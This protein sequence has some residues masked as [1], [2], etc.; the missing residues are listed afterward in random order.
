MNPDELDRHIMNGSRAA[1]IGF[2]TALTEAQDR[3]VRVAGGY[4][5]R[6]GNPPNTTL[7]PWYPDSPVTIG[8]VADEWFQLEFKVGPATLSLNLPFGLIEQ[9]WV[10]ADRRVH[11]FLSV[12]VVH[13][14]AGREVAVERYD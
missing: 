5:Q 6:V 12:R 13:H 11:L 10:G 3:Q 9:A 1:K 14:Y 8:Q 7:Q 2:D 4:W